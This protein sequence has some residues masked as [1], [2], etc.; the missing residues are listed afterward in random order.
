MS[1][2]LCQLGRFAARRPDG[3]VAEVE[4][5]TGSD[6]GVDAALV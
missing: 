6:R 3:A 1:N 4:F 2:A 5:E